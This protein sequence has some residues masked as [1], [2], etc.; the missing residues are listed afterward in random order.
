VVLFL[1]LCGPN[2]LFKLAAFNPQNML[3][4]GLLIIGSVVACGAALKLAALG[5]NGRFPEQNQVFSAAFEA[6]VAKH[7]SNTESQF[8]LQ[9]PE[10]SETAG[11]LEAISSAPPTRGGFMANWARV[12]GANGYFLDVSTRESFDDYVDG[13]HDLDVGNV[14]GRVITGLNPGTTYYYRVRPYYSAGPG[15]YSEVMTGATVATD[16][17]TIQATF[18]SSITTNPNAVAIEATIS[19]AIAIYEFL[20]TDP[21]TIQIR[22]RYATTAP[23]GTPLPQGATAQSFFLYYIV[24]WNMF[25]DN[26]RWDAKTNNDRAAN[27]SL[28]NYFFSGSV[29]PS[30]ANGR[31]IN[32]DTPPAMFA[33]GTVGNGGPYDG[34]VTLNSAAPYDFTR[35][36]DAGK[37]DAQRAT[38][39]E[40]DEVLGL[41]SHLN[42]S[43]GN[44]LRPQDLF[45]WS[46][47]GIRNVTSSGTRYFSINGGVT[48]LVDFSQD[49]HTDF[50]DWLSTSCPQAHPYVQN[51][52]A[53][54]GQS[55]DVTPTSPEGVN[56]DV[57]GYDWQDVSGFLIPDTTRRGMVFDFAGENLY[58]STSAGLIK[59]FNLSTGSIVKTYNLGGSLNGIDIA[60]DNSFILAAQ[61]NVASSQGRFQRVNLANGVIT[62][63]HYTLEH[64]EGGGWD[65]AIAANGVALVSTRGRWG[66]AD[67][68]LR[69]IDLGTNAITV[70]T[71]APGS[72]FNNEVSEAKIYRSADGTRLLFMELGFTPT[73]VFTYSAATDTFGNRI[74]TGASLD[75]SSCALNRNGSLVGLR[76]YGG[77]ASLRRASD[78]SFVHGFN[79]ID[80]GATFDA[81]RDIFYGINS[82]T[83]QIIAYSTRTYAE[84]FRLNIG[85]NVGAFGDEFGTG[86]FIASADGRWLALE[87]V[88]GIR[89]LAVPNAPSH[90]A[91]AH[92]GNI[93]TRALVQTG[94]NVM[95]GGFIVQG[96]GPKPVI[97]RAIGPELAQHGITNPLADP[98][99]ELHNGTGALIA[100]NNNW[101]TTILGGVVTSNQVSAIQNSGHAPTA[102]SES[103][104][105]ANLQPGNYTAIVRGVNNTTGVALVEVYDLNPAAS[106]SLGN[107]STRSLAQIGQNVM[108]GGFIVQ[109]T[110]PK[111]VIIRAIGPELT[112]YGITNSLANPRL[113]LHNHTG[114]LIGS[115][116]NWQTTIL[117][118]VITGDQV[119][120]IQNSGHAPTAASESAIIANLQPG[121]YTAIV[122]GVNNTRGVALVDVFDLN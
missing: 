64:S 50:G 12:S 60:R 15:S 122:R 44:D 39:H 63:I 71:D 76:M 32:L 82:T 38:E 93:S 23:N 79:E 99:L 29:K 84:L 52:L 73:P 16:G 110:G 33:N 97:I 69:Q 5:G 3:R 107:I 104:I 47:P 61:N 90:T 108:I 102:A 42:I 101:Q 21:I 91:E 34:I 6:G 105:I 65:V 26:L 14:A 88:S 53:C 58:F 86:T 67:T 49:P 43:S 120:Q 115:N 95:I 96:P 109:G 100:S 41:G 19:R 106:S 57:I 75:F 92:L 55:S 24:P 51:A 70:R 114:A 112:Q 25:I 31:A 37:F 13:Y 80:G 18:D 103:A 22:F 46:S 78:L 11:D 116:D 111:R 17:L 81:V 121:N 28:G 94:Q 35:P 30:S 87:T 36:T 9:G 8:G 98:R 118:G 119:S 48:N 4:P 68:P 54:R 20:F 2:R 83:D 56:L 113:E 40:I 72:G 7:E 45:N 89:V 10:A 66:S 27:A 1:A 74:N 77:P 85:E 62:N 117:G 59:A